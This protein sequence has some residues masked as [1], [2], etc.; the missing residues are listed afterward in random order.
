MTRFN[1]RKSLIGFLPAGYPNLEASKE[2]LLALAEEADVLEIGI[3]FSDPVADGP[4]IQQASYV[5][6]KNGATP[7]ACLKLIKE[8]KKET[9]KPIAILTYYNIPYSYGIGKF[10]GDAFASGVD[11][12]LIAD[13]NI[14]ESQEFESACR[15]NSIETIFIAAPNTPESRVRQIDA[16]ATAFI[17][18]LSH[19]A[20]TGAKTEFSKLT[21]DT[22]KRLKP[23]VRNPLAVGFGIST[24]EQVQAIFGA[25]ADAAIV[26][27]AFVKAINP[28]DIGKSKAALRKL[29][30]ELK[31]N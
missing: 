30:K 28:A 21:T 5:A 9:G 19:F 22:I 14:D 4:T 16:H 24:P 2:L 23:L 12:A 10:L 20:V 31:G 15:E 8:V 26:G 3:P 18:L 1:L 13:L 7:N 25:G 29:A 6:I 27:S 17:Y 11:A